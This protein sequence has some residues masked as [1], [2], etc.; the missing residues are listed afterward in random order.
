MKCAATE[1]VRFDTEDEAWVALVRIAITGTTRRKPV[2]PYHCTACDGWHLTGLERWVDVDGR[3]TVARD[4]TPTEGG[5][6]CLTP[7]GPS[8]ARPSSCSTR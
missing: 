5:T 7:D 8:G 2:R 6:G 3:D 1:K 4:G